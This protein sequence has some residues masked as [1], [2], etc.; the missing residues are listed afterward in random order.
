MKAVSKESPG[1]RLRRAEGQDDRKLRRVHFLVSPIPAG[2]IRFCVKR[3]RICRS[4]NHAVKV[5]GTLQGH[6]FVTAPSTA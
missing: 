3:I 1:Q 5:I 6:A 4:R 2:L